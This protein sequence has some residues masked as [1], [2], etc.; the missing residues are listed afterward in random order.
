M[1]RRTEYGVDASLV[2]SP[3]GY[4]TPLRFVRDEASSPDG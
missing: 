4:T 2:V 3:S 1:N